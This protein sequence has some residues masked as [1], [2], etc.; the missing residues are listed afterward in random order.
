MGSGLRRASFAI[1][2][3][4][5]GLC[6]CGHDLDALRAGTGSRDGA[7]AGASGASAGSGGA[8][9]SVSRACE[10]CDPPTAAAMQLGLRSCCRGFGDDE[11][12]LTFGDGSLCLPRMIPGRPD[13]AC[14]GV[15][16]NGSRLEGCCR[17]DA[18]CGLSAGP[19]GLGCVAR[20]EILA[21][22]GAGSAEAVACTY[23]CEDDADCGV[24]TNDFVCTE[25]PRD[26]SRRI[27]ADGCQRDQDCRRI[28]GQVCA[29]SN[30]FGTD[31]IRTV[32]RSPVGDVP[33]G[34]FCSAAE[35]CVHGVCVRTPGSD[36]FCTA[37][38]R[39]DGDCESEACFSS[40]IS[41]PSGSDTQA[42]DICGL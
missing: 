28:A 14:S 29:L 21:E 6:A 22:L 23:A 10:P 4:V 5:A 38:C 30:D 27:C 40:R 26:T 18:R 15:S 32:C 20:E 37:L 34:D 16:A 2:S 25:D 7:G 33:P 11:C 17:P 1:I 3:L 24:G 8:D 41:R 35:E 31:T 19:L 12:G 9:P 39:N 42:I 36:P 13:S